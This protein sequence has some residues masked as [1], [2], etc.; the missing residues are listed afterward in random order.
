MKIILEFCFGCLVIGGAAGRNVSVH[1][2]KR[3]FP[4]NPI[5]AGKIEADFT[6][7]SGAYGRNKTNAKY[8]VEESELL[9]LAEKK[10]A[11]TLLM[12]LRVQF[13]SDQQAYDSLHGNISYEGKNVNISGKKIFSSGTIKPDAKKTVLVIPT[14]SDFIAK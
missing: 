6:L 8:I 5:G 1:L 7:I 10:R 14:K 3:C 9:Y 2:S 11:E 13:P 4:L 12:S